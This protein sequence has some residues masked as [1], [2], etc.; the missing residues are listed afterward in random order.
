MDKISC[1]FRDRPDKP[2]E[3][4][5]WWTE[6]ILRQDSLDALVPYAARQTWYQRRLLDVWCLALLLLL[7]PYF[8]ITTLKKILMYLTKDQSILQKQSLLKKKTQ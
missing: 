2:L 1:Q 5:V 7:F 4:A 6:Y 3:T 8:A